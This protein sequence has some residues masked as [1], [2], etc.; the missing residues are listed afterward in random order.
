[1]RDFPLADLGEGLEE[2]TVVRWLVA[3]GD[4]VELNQTLCIVETAKAE[5]EV[6]SPW[7]GTIA[8]LG[9]AEGDTIRVGN[10]LTRIDTGSGA[11]VPPAA[12]D[13]PAAVEAAPSS[14]E[15]TLVG[16]GH[17]DSADRSRRQRRPSSGT[18]ATVAPQGHASAPARRP[19]AKPPVRLLARRHAIDLAALAPGTG[20]GGIVTRADVEAALVSSA[21]PATGDRPTVVAVRGVRAR[22]AERMTISRT[23]I[24]DA[25][26]SVTA[27]CTRLLEVRAA[28]NE[29]AEW[30]GRAPV[31]TPFSLLARFV[32]QALES[33][34]MLNATFEESGPEIRL[35]EAVHLGIGTATDRGLIVTVAR[36]AGR[37]SVHD[38]SAELARL[39]ERARA[40]TAAPAELSGSTFTIS[41]FGALGL[42]DGIPIINH[43]E[44][45]ILGVGAIRPRPH[46]VDGTV[47][48]R[49]T[50]ALT[51]AFDHRVCDG[52][53]AG[54]FLGQLRRTIEAPELAL[55]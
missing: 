20:P 7:G 30:G 42:D 9:G 5:V 22:I 23:R 17:D 45:A 3:V 11:G 1:M 44:A 13:R 51:L 37:R 53:E 2:A 38:L 26:C 12:P 55:L 14:R 28:L 43:P 48:A 46:V 39:S 40:G 32:V 19:L 35:H 18:T 4:Q 6:P 31:I 41:N 36:D 8:A 47:V 16:Y 10:L 21:A 29:Y 34:P 50:A 24:P 54:R 25:T 52:A 49:P 33:N 15:P 27:D